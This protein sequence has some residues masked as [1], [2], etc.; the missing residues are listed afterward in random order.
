[1]LYRAVT[2]GGGSTSWR[3]GSS[4][5]LADCGDNS[6]L[7][8]ALI[9]GTPGYVPT[10]PGY[11]NG[12]NTDGGLGWS[13]RGDY[14]V[15]PSVGI[16]VVVGKGRYQAPPSASQHSCSHQFCASFVEC[17][18]LATT[19]SRVWFSSCLQPEPESE[20]EPEPEP[21]HGCAPVTGG[22]W[23]ADCTGGNI[24][25]DGC[26]GGEVPTSQRDPC[27][28]GCSC[29]V[30]LHRMCDPS[31]GWE[32]NNLVVHSDSFFVVACHNGEWQG[33]EQ[34]RSC[35]DIVSDHPRT[36]CI[37]NH[38]CSPNPCQNGGVCFERDD[39]HDYDCACQSGFSGQNCEICC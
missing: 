35:T 6:Y 22:G 37:T 38:P 29:V 24:D 32:V 26:F 14:V 1:M 21:E 4:Y 8:S 9:S 7:N 16:N 25:C 10:A 36:L 27:P 30:S 12:T 18:L 33:E 28:H 17:H 15:Y 34:C 5:R 20:P 2:A 3:V 13:E 31:R 19:S 11:S 23:A 39:S